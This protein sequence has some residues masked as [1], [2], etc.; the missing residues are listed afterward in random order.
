MSTLTTYLKNM[1]AIHAT[2]AAVAETSYYGALEALLNEVGNTLAPRVHAVLTLQNQGAGLPDGGLFT[3]DQL[4]Q[5]ATPL[6]GQLPARGAMEVKGVAA[7]VEQI[8]QTAQVQGYLAQYGLVLVTNY[9]DFLLLNQQAEVVER[10]TLADSPTAFWALA[11]QPARA[12][13]HE[14][15]FVEFLQRVMQSGAPISAPQTLAW[16]LAS[17]GR[18][19]LARLAG[20][21][22]LA[23]Q[24]LRE[25][26]EAALGI[27]F[28][29]ERGDHFFRSTLVQTLF[30]GIFSAWVLWSRD[31]KQHG[32]AFDWRLTPW[33]LHVPMIR[34]LFEQ[35]S[36]PSR[37]QALGIVEMLDRAG[38]TLNRVDRAAFFAAFQADE[39]VQYFYEPFL[40]QFDPALRKQ[41]GVWYTPP[42][43]VK[44]M[45]GRVD[46]VLREELGVAAGL[47]D[48]NVLILDPACGT[49]A[50]LVEVLRHIAAQLGG[51]AN[52]LLATALRQAATSR[53]YGFEILPAP[54][55]VAHLQLGLLLQQHGASLAHQEERVAVYLTNALTGWQERSQDKLPLPEFADERDA[56]EKIK[57]REPILVVLGNPPYNGY[58][59]MALGE[60]RD[61]TDAYRTTDKAPKPQGQGLNDLYVRFFRIAERQIV[62]QTG[63]GIVCFISNYSW[64][65]G[66]SFTGMREH[67]M[68]VFDEIWVD[69]LNGDKY[70]TGKVTPWGEPDPSVFSTAQNR[71][72]IQVGTAIGLLLRGEAAGN[73]PAAVRYRDLWGKAKCEEL[74]ASLTQERTELYQRL[75][76]AP[77]LGLPLTPT[78]YQGDYLDWPLLP[79][80]FP[81]SFPG[82]KTSRDDVLVEIDREKLVARMEKY[83]DPAVSNEEIAQIAPR[84]VNKASR[85]NALS[86]RATLLNKGFE[87]GR[88]V[89]YNYRPFDVRWLYWHPETKLLDEKRSDY[90]PHVFEDNCSLVSQ[91]KPRRDWSM[92][93]V[94][95]SMGCLDLMDRGATCFPLYLAPVKKDLFDFA[96]GTPDVPYPNLSD[97]AHDYLDDLAVAPETLFYHTIA[98]LHAPD[99][100][101]ENG[102]AL[103]QDWPRVPLPTT[104]EALQQSAALGRRLAQLLDPEQAVAMGTLAAIG[105]ITHADGG[106]FSAADLALTAGWGYAGRAG[107]TMPGRGKIEER[108]YSEAERD[109]LA[110]IAESHELAPEQVLALLG[111]QTTDIYL[112]DVAYWRNVPSRVW[113]YT[114]GGYPVLKKWLSYREEPLLG[115][116]LTVEEVSYISEVVRRIAAILLMEPALNGSYGRVKGDVVPE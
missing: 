105:L 53:I 6:R 64:L 24:T 54:F 94:I 43:I 75:D 65:D 63:R 113:E 99:Y 56:A 111:E 88:V 44:Y 22:L 74:L 98:T 77:A 34:A 81:T 7:E 19:A 55:V 33:L 90:F 106:Q 80:L 83:F 2:G 108:A 12:A 104:A 82:V 32:K 100:R 36:L 79:D 18:Q 59:G 42:E 41:L 87:T 66:L 21:N 109:T 11:Q 84:L 47:A 9:R 1:H 116:P 52:P 72:G 10:Y 49:G 67:F 69:N 23:L 62:E 4:Q 16:F 68:E 35:V 85:F 70:K 27:R 26:M 28:E 3:T 60:E 101:I 58:A 78:A 8:A 37:V 30:Y 5:S 46:Q 20:R 29:G 14:T 40:E 96:A 95:S 61:L 15:V 89:R 92:P 25:T 86:V 31:P 17:Y 102:G 112:N 110:A 71:E 115:R 114:L 48:E 93:Q 97:N 103:R 45:I 51:A 39:A 91:Q 13:T 50:Y 38:A 76:P 73:G 57:Q 107:I